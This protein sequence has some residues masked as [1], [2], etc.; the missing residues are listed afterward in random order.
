[1]ELN[2]AIELINHKSLPRLAKSVW[3]DIGCGSGLFTQALAS[4]LVP[5]SKIYAIDQ[6]AEAL[7]KIHRPKDMVV[8]KIQSDFV[9]DELNLHDLDGIVMANSI[10]FV[11]DKV[12]FINKMSK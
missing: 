10:H 7:N 2:T 9:H 6:N 4:L 1:M 3:A 5:G 11:R 12:S 8:E